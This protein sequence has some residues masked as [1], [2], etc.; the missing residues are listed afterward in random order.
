MNSYTNYCFKFPV[1]AA[2]QAWWQAWIDAKEAHDGHAW[3][4]R[5]DLPSDPPAPFPTLPNWP[6]SNCDDEEIAEAD[7]RPLFVKLDNL[8]VT[9]TDDNTEPWAAIILAQAYLQLFAPD[10]EI[11]FTWTRNADRA[12]PDGND[13]GAVVVTAKNVWTYDT[14]TLFN[15]IRAERNYIATALHI[16]IEN[17]G[18]WYYDSQLIADNLPKED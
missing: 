17:Y 6:P 10:E 2:S 1:T 14:I 3:S 18:G 11:Q 7:P 15:L 8:Q 5:E 9:I 13:S 16:D 12:I 4:L